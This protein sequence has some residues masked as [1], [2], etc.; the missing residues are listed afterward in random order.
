V[1]RTI[2]DAIADRQALRHPS[3]PP[4]R[5]YGGRTASEGVAPGLEGV[6][7]RRRKPIGIGCIPRGRGHQQTTLVVERHRRARHLA[8]QDAAI[9]ERRAD[10][11]DPIEACV[12]S[13]SAPCQRRRAGPH[14]DWWTRSQRAHG[15]R[16]ETDHGER[17]ARAG[18]TV[19]RF[20]RHALAAGQGDVPSWDRFI[21]DLRG[22]FAGRRRP[23]GVGDDE[24]IAA[25]APL[26]GGLHEPG[27]LA[28]A[29]HGGDEGASPLARG[30]LPAVHAGEALL[31]AECSHRDARRY[32]LD[33]L[34][35][36]AEGQNARDARPGLELE[37]PPFRLV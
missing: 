25:V 22:I 1:P 17:S 15:T 32:A 26:K 21:P 14:V 2:D 34:L 7:I 5:V 8:D 16:V 23:I 10:E 36:V 28:H 12:C 20:A 35:V 37:S 29:L 31:V 18:Q 3:D 4:V 6:E 19:L 13:L 27:Q 11:T 9:L 30:E 24:V 33:D